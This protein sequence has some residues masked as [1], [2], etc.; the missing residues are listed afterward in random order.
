MGLFGPSYNKLC[1]KAIAALDAK[2]LELASTLLME[3]IKKDQQH[4]RAFGWLGMTYREAASEFSLSN[5]LAKA[6]EY[7]TM[8]IRAFNEA[9][10]RETDIGMKAQIWWQLGQ[11]QGMLGRKDDQ[12]LSF[13]EA[14]K[15]IPNF[16]K[17]QKDALLGQAFG[18]P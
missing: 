11:V 18:N 16:I 5:D 9:I 15:L 4:P 12:R 14:D 6:N 8:A 7:G 3:A 13:A 1:E 17:D 2:D 10:L